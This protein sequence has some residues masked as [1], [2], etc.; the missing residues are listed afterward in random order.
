MISVGTPRNYKPSHPGGCLVRFSFYL[1]KPRLD[2]D[3]C[4]DELSEYDRK[5]LQIAISIWFLLKIWWGR[6]RLGG[7]DGGGNIGGGKGRQYWADWMRPCLVLSL[8]RRQGQYMKK[9]NERKKQVSWLRWEKQFLKKKTPPVLARQ[10]SRW[11]WDFFFFCPDKTSI[12]AHLRFSCELIT[13]RAFTYIFSL[14]DGRW[15]DIS[16]P[17]VVN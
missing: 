15:K 1:R 16:S 13:D 10:L 17:P 2:Q 7:L 11:C 3:F 6:H 5:L 12:L 4:D 9:N 8:L 14:T